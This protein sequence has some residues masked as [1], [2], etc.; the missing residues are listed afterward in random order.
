MGTLWAVEGSDLA[1][2]LRFWLWRRQETD[3]L[4]HRVSWNEGKQVVLSAGMSDFQEN[5]AVSE[6]L[7]KSYRILVCFSRSIAC[8][9][10]SGTVQP[11]FLL[12]PCIRFVP[13]FLT[14]IQQQ[15]L[16]KSDV[17]K[18][19]LLWSLYAI[20]SYIKVEERG[21]RC[22]HRYCKRNAEKTIL[23][24]SAIS[25]FHHVNQLRLEK[26]SELN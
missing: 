2:I 25:R 19:K 6:I 14:R 15:H 21:K 8:T 10:Y 12:I 22:L 7:I 5:K 26:L 11:V 17:T 4:F 18:S 20:Y 1:H 16:L 9:E 23:Q 3:Q 13:M 24:V